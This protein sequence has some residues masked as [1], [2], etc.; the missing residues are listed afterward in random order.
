MS[1]DRTV[2]ARRVSALLDGRPVRWGNEL[3]GDYDG[4]ER[5]LEVFNAD[6]SE[7]RALVSL[8]RPLR[9]E[10]Q[11]VLGGP[12]VV[13]FHTRSQSMLLYAAF[14]EDALR[15]DVIDDVRTAEASPMSDLP[16]LGTDVARRQ[17][18][19]DQLGT[20]DTGLPRKAAA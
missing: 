8:L 2:L 12:V 6:A 10:L 16:P 3:I 17:R 19:G 5:T 11:A 4:R 20:G 14:V 9:T 13:I 18:R 1:D 7:Q 15:L